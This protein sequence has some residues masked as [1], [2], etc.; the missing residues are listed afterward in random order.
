MVAGAPRVNQEAPHQAARALMTSRSDSG[1]ADPGSAD[2]SP[3]AGSLALVALIAALYATVPMSTDTYT[4][5]LG[6]LGDVF[7]AS[8]AQV[9]LTMSCFLLVFAV[10]Q[11]LWGPISDGSGRRPVLFAAFGLYLVATLACLLA[12]SIEVLILGRALQGVGAA[13]GPVIGL[14]MVRDIYG[15][16]GSAKM[17]ATITA[18]MALAPLLAPLLAA[19]LVPTLGWQA[20]FWVLAGF[21]MIILLGGA[22]MPETAPTL[23]GNSFARFLA[24]YR[25]LVALRD[26]G[27]VALT[28]GAS[29]CGVFAII[30]G[31][32]MVL[33]GPGGLGYGS[34]G[35][36]LSFD[37]AIGGYVAG[38]LVGRRLVDGRGVGWVQ[39]L[40]MALSLPSAL[41]MLG[42]TLGDAITWPGMVPPGPEALGAAV[43]FALPMLATSSLFMMGIGMTMPSSMTAAIRP[44]PTRAGAASALLGFIRGMLAAGVGF[45]AGP[46]HDGSPLV[47]ALIMVAAVV[48]T[49]IFHA[50]WVLGQRRPLP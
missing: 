48:A 19:A 49:M 17:F 1:S 45:I 43:I 23:V 22:R 27:L 18:A 35:Y 16:K 8:T 34:L 28:H 24:S 3:P 41:L 42:L 29:Y 15:Q 9:Q 37:V 11:L 38:A 26:Y 44:H 50:L 4:P 30:S 47:M 12:P 6:M 31:L 40:G 13:A 20:P 5:V 14:A 46:Y 21:A 7:Q 33:T 2:R 39:R 25:H 10:F 36:A 32:A